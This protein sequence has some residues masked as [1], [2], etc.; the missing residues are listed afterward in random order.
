MTKPVLIV[1]HLRKKY[2]NFVAVDDLSFT[3]KEGEVLGLLG[4][5]G[6]GKTTTI[7]MLL[8]L[9]TMTSGKITYFG[10]NFLQHRSESLNLVNYGS[11]Y[12]QVP[13]RLT[14]WENLQVYA[15]LY[16]VAD[17]KKRIEF[18]LEQFELTEHRDKEVM[19]LSAGQKTRVN[20]C[21]AFINFPR[22]ILLDE[23]TASLDPDIAARVREFIIRQQRNFGVAVLFTS[24]NMAEV[25]EVCDRVIFLK[26]GRVIAEDTPESLARKIKHAQLELLVGDGM[27]RTMAFAE[28]QKLNY[29]VADRF[30]RITIK[31]KEIA[32]FLAKLAKERI[33]YS[34]ISISKPTLEDFFLSVSRES[35][36]AV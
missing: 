23:P 13:A 15:R 18:L 11:A 29:V 26:D 1:D 19:S 4:P 16:G 2:G 20:L 12:D 31:E 8:G 33:S 14:V 35:D 3:L 28:K 25:T 34:E 9:T 27:K 6:A 24:H 30:I 22:V 5:N 7:Q 17:R 21:K 32:G 10:K 36:E